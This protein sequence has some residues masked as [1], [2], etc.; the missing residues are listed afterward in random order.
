MKKTISQI[1][2]VAQK[3]ID[4]KDLKSLKGGDTNNIIIG[5]YL[6]S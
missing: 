2:E 5:D 4:K 6:G 3:L 1:K